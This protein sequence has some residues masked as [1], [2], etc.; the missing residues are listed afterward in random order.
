MLLYWDTKRVAEKISRDFSVFFLIQR[1][2]GEITAR[3]NK[4]GN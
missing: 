2:I 3:K 4:A 1:E